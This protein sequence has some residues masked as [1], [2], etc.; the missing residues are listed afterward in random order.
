[1]TALKGSSALCANFLIQI[2]VVPALRAAGVGKSLSPINYF[3]ECVGIWVNSV[4]AE[5]AEKLF[6]HFVS[7]FEGLIFGS[8]PIPFN[9][10]I[11]N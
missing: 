6:F 4:V 3:K 5:N 9:D 10:Y 1:M 11:I 2:V 8:A 7:S